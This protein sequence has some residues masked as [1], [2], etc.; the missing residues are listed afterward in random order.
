MIDKWEG[1]YS[2]V[3]MRDFGKAWHRRTARV[4]LKKTFVSEEDLKGITHSLWERNGQD[5]DELV[6]VFYLPGMDIGSLAYGFGS[7]MKDGVPK[8]SYR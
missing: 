1:I 8:I 7:C 3:V 2:V 4:Q 5:V 6:T